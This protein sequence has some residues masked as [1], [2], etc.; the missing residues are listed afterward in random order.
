M[1]DTKSVS[2]TL[3][4]RLTKI[5]LMLEEAVVLLRNTM[6]EV[7]DEEKGDA[8]YDRPGDGEPTS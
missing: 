3:E 4:D 2:V 5:S 8:R 7:K 1:A 6:T